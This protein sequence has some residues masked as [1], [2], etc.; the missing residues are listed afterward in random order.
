MST[1]ERFLVGSLLLL[2]AGYVP[3]RAVEMKVSRDA[4]ERTLNQQLIGGPE[5]TVLP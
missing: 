1:C 2:A 5:R 3:A 4:L